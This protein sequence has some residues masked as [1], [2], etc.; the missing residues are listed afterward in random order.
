MRMSSDKPDAEFWETIT[1]RDESDKHV[2]KDPNSP[3][4]LLLFD[5]R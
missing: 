2:K 1:N 4:D 3:F 5:G